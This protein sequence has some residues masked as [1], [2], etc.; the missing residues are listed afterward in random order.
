MRY[1]QPKTFVFHLYRKYSSSGTG[2]FNLKQDQPQALFGFG[3]APNSTSSCGFG[4]PVQC[5]ET[6]LPPPPMVGDYLDV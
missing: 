1:E 3:A 5:N 6:V 4:A 2:L